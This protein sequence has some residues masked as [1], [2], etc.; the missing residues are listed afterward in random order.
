MIK[1]TQRFL[2]SK[3]ILITGSNK[4]LGREVAK[5]L[6]ETE[7]KESNPSSPLNS[8]QNHQNQKT[9]NS[10]KISYNFIL[11]ARDSKRGLDSIANL[12][13]N[14]SLSNSLC[15]DD[16]KIKFHQLDISNKDSISEC[17]AFLKALK[18]KNI[19]EGG[20]QENEGIIDILL[21]NAG[22]AYPGILKINL[23]VYNHIFPTNV[24]GT[25]N[26]TEQIIKENLLKEK[27]KI[28][29]LASSLGR[30][31]R[32]GEHIQAQFNKDDL[33]KENLFELS[34]KFKFS[35]MNKTYFQEGWGKHAYGLSKVIVKKYA[36]ILGKDVDLLRKQVQ[37]YSC[38]PG[39]T[40][41]DLGGHN[42]TRS[43]EEGVVT[44]LYLIQL[45]HQIQQQV[46]GKFFYD[47]QV[48]EI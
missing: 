38:C 37:V 39:W 44:V 19:N 48:A 11:T 1:I 4:G 42:A 12:K 9:K 34:E 36:E 7:L 45:E 17:I 43:L 16:N 5:K 21:N 41:T 47:C 14:F 33:T 13:Q 20:A 18:Q 22:A 28:I 2:S 23:D 30:L 25:V 35:I 40:K 24:F 46:Q 26:F 3:T 10:K 29:F 27:S 31:S 6:I 15:D 32:L 8:T